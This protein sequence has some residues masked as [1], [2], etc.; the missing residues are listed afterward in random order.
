MAEA[1][2]SGELLR[3][4]YPAA[5]LTESASETVA[6]LMEALGQLRFSEL[7]RERLYSFYLDLKNK[8]GLCNSSILKYHRKVVA[9]IVMEPNRIALRYWTGNEAL[10]EA[11]AAETKKASGAIPEASILNLFDHRPGLASP[12]GPDF[13]AKEVGGSDVIKNGRGGGIRTHDPL[14]PMQECKNL[15]THELQKESSKNSCQKS[16]EDLRSS[17]DFSVVIPPSP[18]NACNAYAT[19]QPEADSRKNHFI[20][21]RQSKNKKRR[22]KMPPS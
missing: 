15:V 14:H 1:R 19:Q 21:S 17:S 22:R 4:V 16:T 11:P 7:T 5:W 18:E 20:K 8:H 3:G 13:G 2:L 6:E 12:L 10:D 9:G